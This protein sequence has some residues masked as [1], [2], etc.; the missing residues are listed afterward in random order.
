MNVVISAALCS[1]S[2]WILVSEVAGFG[3]IVLL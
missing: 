3:A 1:E 2:Y